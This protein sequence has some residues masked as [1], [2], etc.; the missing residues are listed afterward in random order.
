MNSPCSGL[1]TVG[2]ADIIRVE[3]I[4]DGVREV[5]ERINSAASARGE[6]LKLSSKLLM[7]ANENGN[8]ADLCEWFS[9]PYESCLRTLDKTMDPRVLCYR[10]PCLRNKNM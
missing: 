8:T 5:A 7:T 1:S 3:S 9:G 4:N 10:N 2:G 6:K